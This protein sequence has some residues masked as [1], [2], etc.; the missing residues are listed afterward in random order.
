MAGVNVFVRTGGVEAEFH[1]KVHSPKLVGF[2]IIEKAKGNIRSNILR[3]FEGKIMTVL[4]SRT[5]F[6]GRGFRGSSREKK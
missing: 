2:R 5:S 3:E 1:L 6:K 4:E